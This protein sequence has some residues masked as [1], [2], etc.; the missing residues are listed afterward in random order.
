[1]KTG[2]TFVACLLVAAATACGGS[3]GGPEADD[4]SGVKESAVR[5][6]TS[7]GRTLTGHL[8]GSGRVG[9]TLGHMFPADATSWYPSARRIAKAGYMALAFNFRGYGDSG[10]NKQTVKAPI[11]VAAAQR[12]L[13]RRGAHDVA[14]VGASMGG[15]A[16]L[17]AAEG[18]D[19]L[20]IVA[21]SAPARFMG[22]DAI[23]V[24]T[25]V[26]RP[27]LLMASR[28]DDAAFQSVEELER[29]LP[30]P[31]TKIYDGDAHGTNLLDA[32]PEAVDEVISFLQRY[33]PLT[34]T[35]STQSP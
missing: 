33:A 28:N 35:V 2:R 15:T 18:G 8:F 21:I 23:G 6:K 11:D 7:D 27:V 1:V 20:A 14:F 4:T 10:G 25:R 24:S 12:Y 17:V 30:N 34:R 19:A 3:N 13:E 29:A 16:S 31:D 5:F 22:L 26:Q 9:V 32:R